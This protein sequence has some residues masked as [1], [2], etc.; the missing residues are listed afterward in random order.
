MDL[1]VVRAI[2]NNLFDMHSHQRSQNKITNSKLCIQKNLVF[3]EKNC[4]LNNAIL[5]PS[6]K[7]EHE[8]NVGQV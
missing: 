7:F 1:K 2:L 5:T 4:I 3:K 6:S 8:I